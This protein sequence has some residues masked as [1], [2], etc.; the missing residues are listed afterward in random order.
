[1]LT[2]STINDLRQQYGDALQRSEKMASL[3]GT[4]HQAYKASMADL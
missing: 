1:M 4:E 2:N 3:Y